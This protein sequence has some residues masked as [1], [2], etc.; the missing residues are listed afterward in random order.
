MLNP[1]TMEKGNFLAKMILPLPDL[2]PLPHS[3]ALGTLGM[4]G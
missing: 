2:G 1:D 4:P 3:L